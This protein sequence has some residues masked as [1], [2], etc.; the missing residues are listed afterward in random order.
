MRDAKRALEADKRAT[1]LHSLVKA[2]RLVN[3]RAIARA[4]EVTGHARF[5]PSIANLFPHIALEGTRVSDL[6]TR[7]GISKQAVSKLVAELAGDGLVALLPDPLDARARLVRFTDE[8]I[9]A[10]HAGMTVFREIETDLA[11]R[12]GEP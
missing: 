3:E 2:A 10:M 12:V 9:A 7:L 11:S 4:R 8:G 5:R 1:P 6:A